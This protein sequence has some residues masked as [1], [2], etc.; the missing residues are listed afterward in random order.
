MKLLY[1][2]YAPY[3]RKVLL[4]F[5]EKGISFEREICAPFDKAHKA[6]LK[7]VHP[8]GTVPLLVADGEIFTESS[9][10]IEYVDMLPSE[11]PRL[12]PADPR[13]ALRVRAFDRFGDA[14][15][16]GPTAYLAWSL[17]KPAD[18]QN[19]EKIAAQ[20][21]MVSTALGLME[22]PL[23]KSAF[24][25]GDA[26]SMAD[27]SPA[28]AITALLSDGSLGDLAAWPNVAAWYARMTSRP[29][30][31]ATVDECAKVERPPG[32]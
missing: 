13:A 3:C 21:A 9:I 5:F 17:R 12:L 20:R 24:L 4:A 19:T 1:Y 26:L 27:L 7:A 6:R 25:A 30:F 15:L 2:P 16:M 8:L 28:A 22:E 29:S 18:T 14:S 10:I 23:A 11:A 32:F 31:R